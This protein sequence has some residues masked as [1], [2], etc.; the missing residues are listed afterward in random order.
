MWKCHVKCKSTKKHQR[1]TSKK[2]CIWK[3]ILDN[4]KEKMNPKLSFNFR[5]LE[6][7]RNLAIVNGFIWIS[8]VSG[9]IIYYQLI[10]DIIS[11]MIAG[12]MIA[13][14]TYSVI[15]GIKLKL[16]KYKIQKLI[17][18]K[19]ESENSRWSKLYD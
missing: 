10:T 8:L 4:E 9:L 14:L 19:K 2:E 5:W 15:F 11:S 16:E 18:E 17:D 7:D 6:K 1:Q 13:G 3:I 12:I